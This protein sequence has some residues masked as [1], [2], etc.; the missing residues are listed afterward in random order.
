MSGAI[1]AKARAMCAESLTPD[2][3][4]SLLRRNSLSAIISFLKEKERY[5]K[6]FSGANEVRINRRQAEQ[7][8]Q[9]NLFET[10][11]RL[12]RFMSA[13]KSGFCYYYV[14]ECEYKQVLTALIYLQSGTEDEYIKVLPG[15]L[16][17]QSSV[18]LIALAHATTADDFLRVLENTSYGKCLSP[19]LRGK[20]AGE[21]DIEKCAIA[22]YKNYM[23]WVFKALERGHSSEEAKALKKI[24]LRKA[25]LDN[26]FTCYRMRKYFASDIETVRES[27]KPYHYRITDEKLMKILVEP[28]A[29]EL[30]IGLL[31]N[32]FFKD[33]ITLDAENP[34]VAIRRYDYDFSK[35]QLAMTENPTMALY[36]LMTL[37]EIECSNLIKI[38]EGVRYEIDRSEIEHLLVM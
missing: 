14:K 29:S 32:D 10:Y 33:K 22:L 3:Y 12:C 27:L 17:E 34:E 21:A 37:L 6:V 20:N 36:S 1:I 5:R 4:R 25:D 18:D 31:K 38:I 16:I 28:D 11:T 15:Y 2:D 24:F 7:L 30:L 19:L 26:I 13:D 23:R 35:K 9:K 8:L